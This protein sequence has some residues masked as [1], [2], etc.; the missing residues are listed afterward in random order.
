MPELA[1]FARRRGGR[2]RCGR[3]TPEN[4]LGQHAAAWTGAGQLLRSIDALRQTFARPDRRARCPLRRV[5]RSSQDRNGGRLGSWVLSSC[6]RSLGSRAFEKH[7]EHLADVDDVSFA[8]GD[9][10]EHAGL[11]SRDLDVDLVGFQLETG[12]SRETASPGFLNHGRRRVDD[13]FAERWDPDFYRHRLPPQSTWPLLGDLL[14]ILQPG[15][16]QHFGDIEF[17]V[18]YSSLNLLVGGNR[19]F[20]R[21]GPAGRPM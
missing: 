20:C 2:L 4:I 12:S 3:P 6:V 7:A 17:P 1:K 9:R 13:R 11:I 10:L 14:A 8:V 18:N 19:A 16:F 15:F 5:C 21:A